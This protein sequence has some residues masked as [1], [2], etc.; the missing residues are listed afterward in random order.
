M[1]NKHKTGPRMQMQESKH[2]TQLEHWLFDWH[3]P[4]EP[5]YHWKQVSNEQIKKTNDRK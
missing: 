4:S 1:K 5:R 2:T 3:N